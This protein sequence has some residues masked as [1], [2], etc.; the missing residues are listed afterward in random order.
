MIPTE[1]QV[2]A[3]WDKYHLPQIK[4]L[5][6]SLVARVAIFLATKLQEAGSEY[7]INEPLLRAAALLHDIDK[8]IPPLGGEK[9]PD[10]AVRVL[11]EGKMDEVA[12]VVKT[13]PLH[14]IVDEAI[15]PKSWEEKLLY[16]A[17]KM[18]KYEIITVDKRFALW[19]DEHLPK[20]AQA[21]L[22]ACYPRVKA[23]EKEIFDIIHVAPEEVGK[24][25]EMTKLA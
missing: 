10:T 3:L 17:D 9:H 4:R 24:M 18:V 5:H 20:E 19:N 14:A 22:D 11:M 6:A 2:K 21:V 16:L 23:L 7:H 1:D 15:A 25:V 13:H 8:S 12:T